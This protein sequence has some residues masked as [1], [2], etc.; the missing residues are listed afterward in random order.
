MF[1]FIIP[2]YDLGISHNFSARIFYVIHRGARTETEKTH[3]SDERMYVIHQTRFIK[4]DSAVNLLTWAASLDYA[5]V[6]K[7]SRILVFN[8]VVR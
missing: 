6:G 5:P 2:P 1:I 4:T 8:I 7:R 3:F